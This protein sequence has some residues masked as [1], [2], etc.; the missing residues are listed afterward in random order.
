[1]ENGRSFGKRKV[2]STLFWSFKIFFLGILLHQQKMVVVEWQ[3]CNVVFRI[4]VVV[5]SCKGKCFDSKGTSPCPIKQHQ[6]IVCHEPHVHDLWMKAESSDPLKSEKGLE[7]DAR[8]QDDFGYKLESYKSGRDKFGF[9]GS[10][11][12]HQHLGDVDCFTNLNFQIILGRNH[13][14]QSAASCLLTGFFYLEMII[15]KPSFLY[16]ACTRTPFCC[17]SSQFIPILSGT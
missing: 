8:I 1:M 5:V 6:G 11:G 4:P 13:K 15:N 17:T 7:F 9:Q 10:L 2:D 14:Q 12:V 16:V 3:G